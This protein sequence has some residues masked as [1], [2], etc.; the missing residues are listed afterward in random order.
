MAEMR[1]AVQA[2]REAEKA[3]AAQAAQRNGRA[4]ATKPTHVDVESAS[5]TMI[6]EMR[7]AVQAAREAERAA[8]AEVPQEKPARRCPLAISQIK[9]SLSANLARRHALWATVRRKFP[10]ERTKAEGMKRDIMF[11]LFDRTKTET[12][13]ES[14][15]LTGARCILGLDRLTNNLVGVNK[16]AYKYASIL[17]SSSDTIDRVGFRL[18]LV[19]LRE[20]FELHNMFDDVD[21]SEDDKISRSQF[22]KAVP[23]LEEWGLKSPEKTFDMI[24]KDKCGTIEFSELVECAIEP[25]LEMEKEDIHKKEA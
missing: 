23:K 3:A 1:A 7:A 17:H 4:V 24:D 2:A 25:R 22:T 18:Y 8:A 9:N 15:C 19:Y 16:R 11:D 12:L 21:A 10:L 5:S 20:Y 13:D 6:A 14:E